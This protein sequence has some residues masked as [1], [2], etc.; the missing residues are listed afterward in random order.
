MS[1]LELVAKKWNIGT[2][3]EM[4]IRERYWIEFVATFEVGVRGTLENVKVNPGAIRLLHK[5]QI[6]LSHCVI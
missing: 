4:Y 6:S 1:S 3:S 2:Y 5:K